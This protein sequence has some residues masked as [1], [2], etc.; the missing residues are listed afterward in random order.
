M[1]KSEIWQIF[2]KLLLF[3][4]LFPKPLDEW[5]NSK[6]WNNSKTFVNIARGYRAITS[7]LFVNKNMQGMRCKSKEYISKQKLWPNI[8]T[9]GPKH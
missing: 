6:I 9:K 5:N 3:C 4:S 7:I 1:L 2:Y 8:L